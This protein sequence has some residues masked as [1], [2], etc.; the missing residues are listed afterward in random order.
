ML[1]VCIF[2]LIYESF[3]VFGNINRTINNLQ[4]LLFSFTLKRG[5]MHQ[6]MLYWYIGCYSN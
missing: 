6:T 3:V 1:S 5:S 2:V 4:S